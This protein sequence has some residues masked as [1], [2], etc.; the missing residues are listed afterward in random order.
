MNMALQR[1]RTRLVHLL[2]ERLRLEG[3]EYELKKLKA[4]S[5]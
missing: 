2:F 5:T 3:F 1:L 4:K